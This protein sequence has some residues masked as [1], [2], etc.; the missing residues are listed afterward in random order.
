MAAL[1]LVAVDIDAQSLVN[2][3]AAVDPLWTFAAILCLAAN[4]LAVSFRL[5]RLA[6]CFDVVCRFA[7][8]LRANISGVVAGFFMFQMLGAIVG[9]HHV[10]RRAGLPATVTTSVTYYE[11]VGVFLVAGALCLAGG[12]VLD[13]GVIVSRALDAVPVVE[14]LI[15]LATVVAGYLWFARTGGERAILRVLTSMRFARGGLEF[16]LISTMALGLN[17]LAF[18]FAF[19]AVGAAASPVVLLAAAAIVSFVAGLPISAQ[20]WGVREFAAI[21]VLGTVGV[22]AEAALLGSVIV[23]L[24]A[25]LVVLAGSLLFPVLVKHSAESTAGDR[26]VAAGFSVDMERTL[27]W[28]L[29]IGVCILI[30]FQVRIPVG[31]SIATLNLADPMALLALFAVG[32]SLWSG[33]RFDVFRLPGAWLMLAGMTVLLVLAFLNGVF[34]FGVTPWALTNR[35]MGWLVLCGYVAAGLYIVMMSGR[36]GLRRA[37]ETLFITAALVVLVQLVFMVGKLSGAPFYVPPNFEAFSGNRNALGFLLLVA[38]AGG[39]ATMGL[40]EKRDRALVWSVLL[41][42]ILLGIWYTKGRTIIAVAVVLLSM[43]GLLSFCRLKSSALAIGTAIAGLV[44]VTYFPLLGIGMHWFELPLPGVKETVLLKVP[45]LAQSGDTERIRS[46]LEGLRLWLEHPVFGAGLGAFIRMGLGEHGQALV[47]HSTPVWILAE[48][49]L[50]GVVATGVGFAYLLFFTFQENRLPAIVADR[51]LFMVLVV[52]AL[53]SLPH[54]IFYQ[55][56]FWF[57]LGLTLAAPMT[58]RNP[59]DKPL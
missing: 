37:C 1:A 12:L 23:G 13:G 40:R 42:L 46:I 5:S 27:A 33:R 2:G 26:P 19:W 14:M 56:V 16:V 39:L 31:G 34:Q 21:K 30:F 29:S 45:P 25:A 44:V 41:G 57:V 20:G 15:T 3:L 48:F 11:K 8:A 47:I 54:D 24:G 18:L 53:F 52:F 7:L 6:A 17:Y 59:S 10:L 9:R 28:F 38:A 4:L 43:A 50:V 32:L 58:F 55:R 35:L 22:A 49:G 36:L 51:W